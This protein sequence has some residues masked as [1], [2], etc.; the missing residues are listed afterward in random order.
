[1]ASLL[2]LS[3]TA[4]RAHLAANPLHANVSCVF[5]KNVDHKFNDIRQVV[6]SPGNN[7]AGAQHCQP[8]P[9]P[10]WALCCP[11]APTATREL[12]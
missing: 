12:T 10:S 11:P 6:V 9:R 1:M 2:L 7:T 4:G 8:A 5:E 3:L